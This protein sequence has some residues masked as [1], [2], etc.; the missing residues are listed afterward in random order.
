LTSRIQP[1]HHRFHR[2]RF[3]RASTEVAAVNVRTLPAATMDSRTRFL[4]RPLGSML[5]S[6]VLMLCPSAALAQHR[7][8]VQEH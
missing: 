5:L 1:A 3:P 7:P 2:N 6:L 4:I 8:D